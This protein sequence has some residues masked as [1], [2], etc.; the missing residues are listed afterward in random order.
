[1]SVPAGEARAPWTPL[2]E[3]F[4]LPAVRG[5]TMR[6]A[7]VAFLVCLIALVGGAPGADAQAGPGDP[8]TA[9]G[10]VTAPGDV[11]V[12]VD[13]P[14]PVPL[15]D[16]IDV[17]PP[18]APLP[19]KSRETLFFFVENEG[20]GDI[21]D[22]RVSV[23]ASG[24]GPLLV[25]GRQE[26][27]VGPI[28]ADD[29]AVVGVLVAT[30]AEPSI[31]SVSVTV[32]YVD[33]AGATRTVVR[34]LNVQI[35]PPRSDP[36]TVE[37]VSSEV[38]SGSESFLRFRVT[39]PTGQ[40]IRQL[41]LRMDLGNPQPGLSGA[42]LLEGGNLGGLSG[43]AT[44]AP[45]STP[46]APNGEGGRILRGATLAPG[47]TR[48]VDAPVQ[49]ALD[50]EDLL[51][52]GVTATYSYDGYSR[53]QRFDF[54]IRL[55]GNVSLRVLDLREEQA[56]DQLQ[57]T[58]TI[59]NT[60]QGTAWSPLLRAAPT[61]GYRTFE[62]VLLEDLEPNEAVTFRLPVTRTSAYGDP[63]APPLLLEYNDEQGRVRET[64]VHSEISMLPEESTES[65]Y[66]PRS[67]ARN[68]WVIGALAFAAVLVVAA[69]RRRGHED[70]DDDED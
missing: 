23:E 42:D 3:V 45:S 26:R 13:E 31:T 39:N 12:I 63:A 6:I 51:V 38:H 67:L 44:G 34:P 53:S 29:E 41:D 56:G 11:T 62:P 36:L 40:H 54:G 7:G 37:Y 50:A 2:R 9:P 48:E 68:P 25:L 17:V 43:L 18:L 46:L 35:G 27:I 5:Q 69:L 64:P 10:N 30:P 20:P 1:M 55:A 19:A 15:D 28:E 33:D 16:Q 65:P 47:E 66:A 49:T 8:V 52:F 4:S 21:R 32:T 70:D 61:S 24:G 60:G 59:V 58:G 57:L 22:V 14:T